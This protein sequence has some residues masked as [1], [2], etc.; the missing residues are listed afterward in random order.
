MR[1]TLKQPES[2]EALLIITGCGSCTEELSEEVALR[3]FVIQSII[4]IMPC[5]YSGSHTLV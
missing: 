5:T 2:V 3:V 1:F 4:I